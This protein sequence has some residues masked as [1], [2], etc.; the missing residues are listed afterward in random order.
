MHTLNVDYSKEFRRSAF[1]VVGCIKLYKR[2]CVLYMPTQVCAITWL[3][4]GVQIILNVIERADNYNK[5]QIWH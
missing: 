3:K 2:Y 1:I 5:E 4:D